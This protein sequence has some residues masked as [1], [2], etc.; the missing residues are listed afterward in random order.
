MVLILA[1]LA[2]K[3]QSIVIPELIGVEEQ[4]IDVFFSSDNHSP[5]TPCCRGHTGGARAS[6][7]HMHLVAKWHVNFIWNNKAYD[8]KIQV[9]LQIKRNRRKPQTWESY[10]WKFVYSK[11]TILSQKP[12]KTLLIILP[13]ATT[14]SNLPNYSRQSLPLSGEIV[15]YAD[16]IETPLDR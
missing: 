10:I 14:A 5:R 1:C 4:A 9:V 3:H 8:S 11:T 12:K 15:W 6:H 7:S 13:L 16:L 2:N